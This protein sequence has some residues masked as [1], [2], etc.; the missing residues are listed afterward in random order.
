MKI[1]IK[2]GGSVAIGEY[3]PNPE[4]FS[5]LVSV[6]K[7]VQK[8]HQLIVSIGGGKFVRKYGHQIKDMK[9]SNDE[10]E[11]CFIDLV[12]ANV[13]FLSAL[14]KTKPLFSLEEI[15]SKTSG[16]IGGIKPG[17]STDAN[18]ALAA[19]RIK[20]DLII[21]LTDVDGVYEKD[22]KYFP[23]AKKLDKISLKNIM[24]YA[25]DGK[26]GDYGIFDKL[27]LKTIKKHK[28]KTVIISG[29]E[30]SNILKVLKGEKI[31]TVIE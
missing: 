23:D 10:I 9:L 18:A 4:Y 29:N 19:A 28:I 21:K 12:R 31:G 11:W 1:V 17:R 20:A 15:S 7:E 30:P 2:I 26:P 14:L 6:L 8:K 25:T 13:H 24:K 3:G 27:A 16:V 22:P 5:R